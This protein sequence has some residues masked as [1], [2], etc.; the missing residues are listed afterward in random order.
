MKI[1]SINRD[2]IGEDMSAGVVLG[3]QSIP[4]G[5]AAGLLA[6]INPIYGLYSY[7]TG[8]FFG[9]FFTSSAF[10]SI[11]AT[12][13]MALIVASVPQVTQSPDPNNSLFVLA[14]LTG[15]IMLT[16]GLFK[17]G[18]LVRF[19]PNSVMAGFV[20]AVAVLIILG[21]LD[22][23]TGYSTS[24]P[25]RIVR[26]IDLLFNL[27][28]VHVPTLVVGLLTIILIVTLEKTS[29]KAMGLVVAMIFASLVVPLFGADQIAQ[30]R[31]IAEIPG[32][33]PRPMLPPLSVLPG[34][35]IPAFSLAFVGLV[36]GA[37]ITKSVPNPD[38]KYP[39]ASRDFVGQGIANLFAG[40]LQGM[41][42]GG[43]MSATAL[44]R[45]A[46]ARSRLANMIAGVTMALAIL[47]F[48]RLV[49]LLAMPALAGL[50]IVVG[51]R[52]LKPQ[53]VK[54]VWKTGLVQQV[55]MVFTFV[56][57]LLVPLQYAVLIGV[58]IA[59]MLYVFQQ[60][61]KI[62]VKAW[63][64]EPGRY[65]VESDPPATVPAQRVTILVPYG[66]LFYAAVPV[67]AE[68]LPEVTDESRHAVVILVLHG[69]TDVGSTLLEVLIRYTAALR[70]QESK[71]KLVGVDDAVRNQ[72]ARTGLLYTIGEENVYPATSQ[73]G[74]SLDSAVAAANAWLGQAPSEVS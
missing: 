21:Q 38:G 25:N 56:S 3:I 7:M 74:E 52:T 61:N 16:A 15:V 10:M 57:A 45:S 67:F 63:T 5:M 69:R 54:M 48:G 13:A 23:F 72:L 71:L 31:D 20:N 27:D 55:V 62:T 35:I 36:Q 14:L 53:Q 4:D 29:L 65:P 8:V 73:L 66:S 28:Q 44:V 32:S 11:Q 37:S 9:A 12:S 6:L 22:D 42:V 68:Q 60:S 64:V 19:V 41:P 40:L 34:L 58:G 50:L 24:G 59:V 49:G 26:T 18:T 2:T 39:D 47:L 43:S 30:V 33:L 46:G 70:Q 1:P 51:F 17:L